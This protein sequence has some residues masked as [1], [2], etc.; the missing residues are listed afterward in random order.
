MVK[1]L[2]EAGAN[3][4]ATDISNL[5][6]LGYA[7]TYGHSDIV[8]YLCSLPKINPNIVRTGKF[9]SETPLMHAAWKCSS[10]A[11]EALL[12]IKAD[13]TAI[14][15]RNNHSTLIYAVHNVGGK[16]EADKI[17]SLLID[18]GA[19]IDEIFVKQYSDKYKI[20]YTLKNNENQDGGTRKLKS[21]TR[22][23]RKSKSRKS[24]KSK[25]RK[26]T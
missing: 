9:V 19:E 16:D 14:N 10:E 13:A 23:S 26:S 5:S 25:S 17:I 11:V 7:A 2:V 24:R 3:V 18:N 22:K 1:A 8:I 21:K 15:T 12:D 6:P 4:N 20:E